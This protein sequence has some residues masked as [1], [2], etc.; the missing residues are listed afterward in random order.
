MPNRLHFYEEWLHPEGLRHGRIGPAA[1]AAVL[2][3]LRQEGQP[4]FLVTARA[5]EHA[6]E[7]TVAG[8]RPLHRALIRVAPPLLRVRL[9]MPVVRRMVRSTAA[10]SRAVVRLNQGIGTVHLS[11]SVF[12]EVRHPVERPLCDYYASAIRRLLHLVDLEVAVETGE[13]RAAGAA[14]C[15]MTLSMRR[16][17]EAR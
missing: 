13:C 17:E 1:V 5:G 14:G 12:C 2:S 16:T 9:V 15:V 7:W 10:G 8:V 11:G 6:A 4:Y 3:F